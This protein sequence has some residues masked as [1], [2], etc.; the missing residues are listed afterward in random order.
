VGRFGRPVVVFSCTKKMRE[1]VFSI[2][3][4]VIALV[5]V[6]VGGPSASAEPIQSIFVNSVDLT[7]WDPLSYDYDDDTGEGTLSVTIDSFTVL[8]ERLVAGETVPEFI[9]GASFTLTASILTDTSSAPLASG[10]FSALSFVLNDAGKNVLLSGETDLG[11]NLIYTESSFNNAMLLVSNEIPITGGLLQPDF[12]ESAVING[13]V[14]SI[15]PT[16]DTIDALDVDH[17]GSLLLS[18]NAVPEPGSAMLLGGL[19]GVMLWRRR[20]VR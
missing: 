14:H 4:C 11:A 6:A 5:V 18:L 1:R 9:E 3:T 15:S 2:C 7:S 19:A 12:D 20:V 16:T 8:V 17:S 10:V 13:L